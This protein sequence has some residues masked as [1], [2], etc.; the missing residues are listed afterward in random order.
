MNRFESRLKKVIF[1][2]ALIR[3]RIRARVRAMLTK[4]GPQLVNK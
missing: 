4:P 1:M 3:V 2:T